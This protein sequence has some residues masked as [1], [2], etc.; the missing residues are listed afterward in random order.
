MS[1]QFLMICD[2]AGMAKLESLF[3]KETVQFLEVQGMNVAQGNVNVLVTPILA[4]VNPMA[5]VP[6][7]PAPP[8]SE[9]PVADAVPAV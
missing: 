6:Q 3:N 2:E 7:P 9:A 8:E 1:R 4:P 5:P